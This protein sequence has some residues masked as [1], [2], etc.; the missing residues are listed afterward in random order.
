MQFNS[1]QTFYLDKEAVQNAAEVAITSIDLFFKLK[2]SATNNKSG[3]TNP[4]CEIFICATADSI[5]MIYLDYPYQR[6]RAEYTDIRASS[7][8]TTA[9]R[10][11][12]T[13]PIYVKTDKEY[14][15]VVKFDGNEDFILW[16]SKQGDFLVGTTTISPGP[17]G[18]YVGKY[19]E[20]NGLPQGF[21]TTASVALADDTATMKNDV[22]NMVGTQPVV[23]PWRAVNDTD[24]K[25]RV[26]VARHAFAGVPVEAN[27]ALPSNTTLVT[28]LGVSRDT[29]TSMAM[30]F[31]IPFNNMEYIL[32]D[33]KRSLRDSDGM[34]GAR[35]YQNTA[36]WPG[37]YA[38]N[39]ASISLSVTANSTLVTANTR[40]P[41]G[42]LFAWSDVFA[43]GN[44]D[45]YIVIT[46]LLHDAGDRRVNV[47]KA[48]EIVSNTVLRLDEKV[49]FSNSAANFFKSPVGRVSHIDKTNSF[50][51]R[52]DLLI[53]KDSNSNST[54]RFVNNCIESANSSGGSG[55]SNSDIF[56]V[57]GFENVNIENEGGYMAVGNITTNSTGGITAIY[58]ANQGA[59]FNNS[60]AAVVVIANSTSGNTTGN[61]SAG[62]GA[63]ITLT[64]DST[65]RTEY[66]TNLGYFKGAQPV[67]LTAGQVTPWVL[68]RNPPGTTYTMHHQIGAYEIDT[69][70]TLSGKAHLAINSA[71]DT[72]HQVTPFTANPIK[73]EGKSAAVPSRGN[74][75]IINYTNGSFNTPINPRVPTENTARIVVKATSNNDFQCISIDSAPRVM[76]GYYHINNDYT[77]EHTDRGNAHSKHVTSKVNFGIN[78]AA[79]DLVVFATC[80]RPSNTSIKV[81]A[82]VHNNQDSDAF[83]D[84]DWTLLEEKT[85][86]NLVSSSSKSD[87]YVEIQYGF[88]QYPNTDFTFTGVVSTTNASAEIVGVGTTFNDATSNVI[89]GDLIKLYQPLFPN[90]YMIA[91]INT[92]TNATHM[93]I[94]ELIT[95][96]NVV[97]A[98]LKIDKLAY[99][100]QVF[101]NILNDNVSRYY[102]STMSAFD[103]FDTM[104]FK[105]VLLSDNPSIIPRVDDIRCIGVSS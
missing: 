42:S 41:N 56:Y 10:F 2:P 17:S 97:G 21:Q 58:I 50:G 27:S 15:I 94:D 46:S 73:V 52:I 60:S 93:T 6:A 19:Y 47:R 66:H 36:F 55:Y 25:F 16:V 87:D 86:A 1:A 18:R 75:H 40:Y 26:N 30:T 105:I 88:T 70:N 24:A 96:N 59:G 91:V 85:S 54:V 95:N 104:Q 20:F 72:R 100:H 37:S 35:V 78:R 92:V 102:S 12:F 84:K 39:S 5:P 57:I 51:G 8:A 74:E 89:S 44:N 90:N 43:M 3:I 29:N 11:R 9:T 33:N 65:L 64:I 53:L 14:A 45:E 38:N 80:Y 79:E 69:A 77:N 61:T 68:V 28:S 34:G 83:D 32:Y 62:T 101:N 99:K 103:T 22:E 31:S 48:V 7:D 67:N 82:R 98:G 81:Y 23:Y 4:G 13:D 71:R 49:T 76:Y 63:T